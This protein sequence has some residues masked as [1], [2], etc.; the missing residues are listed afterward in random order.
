MTQDDTTQL[1]SIDPDPPAGGQPAKVK[2]SG[3]VPVTLKITWG[4][5]GIPETTIEITSTT[6]PLQINVPDAATSFVIHDESGSSADLAGAV[7]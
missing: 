4:P 5:A 1:I 3:T 7:T 2:Y 6:N